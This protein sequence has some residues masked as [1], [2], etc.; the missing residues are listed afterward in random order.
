MK[1]RKRHGKV[2]LALVLAAAVYYGLI[3]GLALWLLHRGYVGPSILGGAGIHSLHHYQLVLD[4]LVGQVLLLSLPFVAAIGFAGLTLRKGRRFLFP[5]LAIGFS[6]AF[7]EIVARVAFRVAGIDIQAY[8]NFSFTRFPNIYVPDD[9]VGYR[10]K[11]LTSG[12]V[13]TADFSIQYDINEHGFRDVP[14]AIGTD[15]GAPAKPLA[16][17]LGD[18]QTFGEGVPLGRRFSDLLREA[19]PAAA[20]QNAGVPGYGLHQM[21][22]YYEQYGKSLRPCAIFLCLIEE[23]I[24][25]AWRYEANGFER[26]EPSPALGRPVDML[27]HGG[28][29]R[30]VGAAI[31]RALMASHVYAY[32]SVKLRIAVV[33][34]RMARRDAQL[35][36][37]SGPAELVQEEA[38]SG[39]ARRWIG[40]LAAAA[41][42]QGA[43]VAVVNLSSAPVPYL[44]DACREWGV[45]YCD[46]SPRLG[47]AT[48]IRYEFD[49]HYNAKGHAIIGE[50]LIAFVRDHPWPVRPCLLPPREPIREKQADRPS[51]G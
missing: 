6:V 46:V 42:E 33:S 47:A 5:C 44:S 13:L 35:W 41:S 25:R 7:V 32:A 49:P 22:L 48:D 40:R 11:P 34:G 15:A 36:S 1:M 50:E 31:H 20:V 43:V 4:R 26:R 16:L 37:R 3:R 19:F 17:F 8:R 21:V 10:M 27:Y 38:L 28:Y 23:D 45:A 2:V 12:P 14:L 9:R 30:R 24:R 39:T 51:G 29:S 18:S